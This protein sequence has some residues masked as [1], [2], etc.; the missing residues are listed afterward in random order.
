AE[1]INAGGLLAAR[2]SHEA[3]AV[4]LAPGDQCRERF[5]LQTAHA[6]ERHGL[7][8]AEP[9]SSKRCQQSRYARDDAE[10]TEYVAE[11]RIDRRRARPEA[12]VDR[13]S[14]HRRT[15]ARG[16]RDDPTVAVADGKQ[17]PARR[18][19]HGESALDPPQAG[20]AGMHPGS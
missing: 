12:G 6:L 17:P 10:P 19:D 15:A 9:P 8:P 18:P 13:K 20:P 1:L 11:S 4:S 2:P 7:S 14:R 16:D 3:R 5:G